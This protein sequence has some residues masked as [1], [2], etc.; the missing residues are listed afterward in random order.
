MRA[1]E[2]YC[3]AD[4]RYFRID[5]ANHW[6]QLTAPEKLNPLLLQLLR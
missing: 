5:G 6:P 2:R 4:F 1:S 3:D